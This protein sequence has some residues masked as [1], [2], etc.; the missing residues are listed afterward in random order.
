[1]EKRKAHDLNHGL[2]VIHKYLTNLTN[3]T[4]LFAYLTISLFGYLFLVYHKLCHLG[5]M[6]SAFFV[7]IGF[8]HNKNNR[9]NKQN[10]Y[11]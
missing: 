5:F 6:Q 7:E 8:Y 2:F 10:V 3:L 9:R 4:N 1:M 11:C